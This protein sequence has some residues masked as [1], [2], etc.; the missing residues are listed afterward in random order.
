MN[1]T[2]RSEAYLTVATIFCG[3]AG[4]LL[5]E[6]VLFSVNRSAAPKTTKLFFINYGGALHFVPWLLTAI[7]ASPLGNKRFFATIAS[8]A[9]TY[10]SVVNFRGPWVLDGTFDHFS[11]SPRLWIGGS[12]AGAM[13]G[14][15]IGS[16]IRLRLEPLKLLLFSVWLLG[17]GLIVSFAQS[18]V[19]PVDSADP[20]NRPIAIV[21]ASIAG[22]ILIWL[23]RNDD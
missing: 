18:R 2:Q 23:K 7:L 4:E 3:L 14:L 5:V 17:F 16:A 22:A 11:D 19:L 20:Q 21:V 12:I 10:Y 9:V 8:L 13:V 1:L 6:L 15:V